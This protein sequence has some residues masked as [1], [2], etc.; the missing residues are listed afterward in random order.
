[1]AAAGGAR[2]VYRQPHAASWRGAS[3]VARRARASP[4]GSKSPRAAFFAAPASRNSLLLFGLARRCCGDI[5]ARRLA[6]FLSSGLRP[7][8]FL[9]ESRP[10]DATDVPRS[11]PWTR[12]LRFDRTAD[13]R[14]APIRRTPGMNRVQVAP[15]AGPH[16]AE[17]LRSQV[18]E[19]PAQRVF[20]SACSSSQECRVR[21]CR[22]LTACR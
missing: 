9:R 11:W 4:G 10:S 14:T 19:G 1:M 20:A 6:T 7:N 15:R 13:V 2:S 22:W 5:A 21:L 3:A 12:I 16:A 8:T 18:T 17:V